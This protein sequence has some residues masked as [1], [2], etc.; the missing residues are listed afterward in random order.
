MGLSGKKIKCFD[1][2][3]IKFLSETDRKILEN[4]SN[5]DMIYLTSENSRGLI[6][7]IYKA[8]DDIVSAQNASRKQII[9]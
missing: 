1:E 3:T 7:G 6:E 5:G 9:F 2:Q 4:Y 8:I